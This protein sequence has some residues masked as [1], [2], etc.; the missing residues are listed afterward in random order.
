M[1]CGPNVGIPKSFWWHSWP[2]SRF[3]KLV[4]AGC[5][6]CARWIRKQRSDNA[7]S[8][9]LLSAVRQLTVWD[10]C[11]NWIKSE[12]QRVVNYEL[13]LRSRVD[14]CLS[15]YIKY[16]SEKWYFYTFVL[17]FCS[18]QHMSDSLWQ[19][20]SEKSFTKFIRH[21]ATWRLKKGTLEAAALSPIKRPATTSSQST[22]QPWG[23]NQSKEHVNFMFRKRLRLLQPVPW[24]R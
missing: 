7:E 14:A 18:V 11:S 20:Y 24:S 17:S 16:S 22:P 19:I 21:G 4:E 13:A 5:H 12:V 10:E 6:F 9:S 2:Q 23:V 15:C 8:A 3:A 1:N